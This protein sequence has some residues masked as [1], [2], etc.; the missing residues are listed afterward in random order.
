MERKFNLQRLKLERLSRNI[1]AK[2]MGEAL[3]I[4]ANA[5][6]RKENGDRNITVE[7]FGII[8]KKLGIPEKNAGIFFTF[9]VPE[10][11]QTS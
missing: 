5:Y 6:Y 11:E 3:G 8:L 10:W 1:T 2:E 4:G 9:N 7:E